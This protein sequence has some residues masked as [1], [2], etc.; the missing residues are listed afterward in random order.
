MSAHDEFAVIATAPRQIGWQ[1][2]AWR[3]VCRSCGWI[4]E[5]HD[6]PLDCGEDSLAHT[7]ET[8]ERRARE[9]EAASPTKGTES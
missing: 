3:A 4:G 7:Y 9:P 8:S 6:H 2:Y 1:G 5:A